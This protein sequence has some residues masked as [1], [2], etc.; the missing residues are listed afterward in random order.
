MKRLLNSYRK[1][2]PSS[3]GWVL[4]I[5]LT[6]MGCGGTTIFQDT[7]PIRIAVAPP[8]PPPQADPPP[9]K[10]VKIRD[11]RIEIGE[12]IQF[13]YD[14]AE[15]L[16]VSFA[17]LDELAK[18]IQENP[19]VQKISIEGHASDEG[20]ENYNLSLSKARA[21]AVRAY[22]VTKGIAADR[23]SSTGYG[24]SKPLVANDTGQNREKNRRVEFN[25]TQQDATREKAGAEPATDTQ[26][27]TEKS[28]KNEGA[29][30]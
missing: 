5:A 26:K 17:L 19:H 12:K 7:T 20:D 18:V 29:Q 28:S 2:T 30:P 6:A 10:Q 24:E 3:V 15:V 11:N 1:T 16:P 27:P 4:G 14:K 22:L 21:E 9:E 13:A 23:L 8:A 25:I